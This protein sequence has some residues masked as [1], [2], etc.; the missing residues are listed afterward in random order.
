ML[1]AKLIRAAMKR[2]PSDVFITGC[3]QNRQQYPTD[4][5]LRVAAVRQRTNKS[6][7]VYDKPLTWVEVKSIGGETWWKTGI[8]S[9]IRIGQIASGVWFFANEQ[10]LIGPNKDAKA[11]RAALD[12]GAGRLVTTDFNVITQIGPGFRGNVWTE[13]VGEEYPYTFVLS[14]ND[15][16]VVV[17]SGLNQY[18]FEASKV[19]FIQEGA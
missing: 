4:D 13:K 12:G 19:K 14:K 2:Y 10:Q 1:T 17:Q 8:D 5:G 7:F 16:Y 9:R 11:K 3:T 6:I 15:S 18:I